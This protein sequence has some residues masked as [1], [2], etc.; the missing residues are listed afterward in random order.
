MSTPR[1]VIAYYLLEKNGGYEVYSVHIED[2]VVLEN[3]RI[4]DPDGWDQSVGILEQALAKQF[5]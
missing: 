4:A 2:D 5:A 1:P 3:K